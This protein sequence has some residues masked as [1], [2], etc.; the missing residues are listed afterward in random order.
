MK[1]R[2]KARSTVEDGADVTIADVEAGL[3]GA[4]D[5]SLEAE[6]FSDEEQEPAVGTL[7]PR[8]PLSNGV[9]MS[10]PA[11]ACTSYECNAIIVN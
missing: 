4:A 7:V 2:Y 3:G 10:E 6:L 1:C 11:K 9:L 8:T 5:H